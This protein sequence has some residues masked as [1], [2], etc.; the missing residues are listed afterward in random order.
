MATPAHLTC[1]AGSAELSALADLLRLVADRFVQDRTGFALV[2]GLAVSAW[3]DPRFTRDIDLAVA[4]GDDAAA[5]AVVASL[6]PSLRPLSVVE[7]EGLGRL[8]MVR[9]ASAVPGDEHG[10]PVVD[11]LFA[12]SGIE[13]EI[14]AAAV[15]IEVL[16]DV[17]VP[18]ATVGHLLAMK[19]LATDDRR[20]LDQQDIVN[21]LDVATSA[22]LDVARA[23]VRLI[24][25][26]GAHRDRDL[27]TAL[28]SWIAEFGAGG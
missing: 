15:P 14:V 6:S 2:G 5:E 9:M 7:H 26:R 24:T 3:T 4:V 22:D 25:E 16:P 21:L 27:P 17:I 19:V 28:E 1:D 10:T 18:L 8:A 11:L 20:R 13:A 12:S 23:G